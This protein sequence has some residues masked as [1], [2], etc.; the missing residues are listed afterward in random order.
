MAEATVRFDYGAESVTVVLPV[1]L[2]SG[3]TPLSGDVSGTFGDCFVAGDLNLTGNL[4]IEGLMTGIDTFHVQGNGF[5]IFF[6][7]GGRADLHGKF[8]A[9]WGPWGTDSTGWVAGNRL[10]IA[11]TAYRFDANGKRLAA[12]YVPIEGL[13]TDDWSTLI[14]PAVL[15]NVILEDDSLAK[16]EVVNLSQSIVFENLARGFH[17]HDSGGIQLLSDLKFLNCGT[18]GVLG[19]YP[20]HF[21]MVGENARGSLLERVVVEGGKNHAFVPHGSHGITY[22]DCA[23]YNTVNH[24]YWWDPPL[25]NNQPSDNDS[26]DIF[27]DHCLA[28]KVTG[29]NNPISARLSGFML[30]R[31]VGNR[32]VGSVAVGVMGGVE[33]SGFHWP[34]TGIGNWIFQNCVGHNNKSFGIFA[35]QNSTL[36]HVIEDFTA[37]RNGLGG[38]DHGAYLNFYTYRNITLTDHPN[39]LIDH[40]LSSQHVNFPN[41]RL[42]FEDILTNG[43]LHIAKHNVASSLPVF[44]RRCTFTAVSYNEINVDRF[45]YIVHEDSGLTPADFTFT[46]IQPQSIVEIFEGGVLQHRWASGVWS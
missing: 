5:T 27:Y 37:Y 1:D 19:N 44:Y 18:V 41:G 42:I 39:A 22:K 12:D 9:P 26:N 45:S 28:L 11:P 3:G 2:P 16:P 24:A 46:L 31:G 21:H 43:P 32:C 36:L 30:G 25:D 14:R 6:Q 29:P 20:H 7:N 38:I 34:E 33:S 10:A 15:P 40:A 8:K 35:W 17:I 13:W 23:A 4:F